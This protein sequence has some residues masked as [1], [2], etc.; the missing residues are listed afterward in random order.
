MT[1]NEWGI[2]SGHLI[3]AVSIVFATGFGFLEFNFVPGTPF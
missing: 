3:N 1:F 2:A